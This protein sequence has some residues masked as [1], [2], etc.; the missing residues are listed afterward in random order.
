MPLTAFSFEFVKVI[1]SLCVFCHNILMQEKSEA[2]HF[3][4]TEQKG[5]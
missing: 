3:F 5:F 4:L 1:D 2:V